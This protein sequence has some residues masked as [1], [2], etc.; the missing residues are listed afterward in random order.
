M[1]RPQTTLHVSLLAK[2]FHLRV[3][4][5]LDADELASIDQVNRVFDEKF[6]ATN[7]HLDAN[8]VMAEAWEDAIDHPLDFE[9]EDDMRLWDMAWGLAICNGFSK[10]WDDRPRPG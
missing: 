9:S 3:S 7:D 2:A 4:E 1:E 5:I 6:C 10:D 8:E